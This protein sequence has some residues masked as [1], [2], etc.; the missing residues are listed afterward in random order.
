MIGRRKLLK[1]FG[2]FCVNAGWFSCIDGMA[3]IDH[4]NEMIITILQNAKVTNASNT[5]ANDIPGSLN[6]LK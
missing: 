1:N 4:Q 2:N 5:V 3:I 6:V